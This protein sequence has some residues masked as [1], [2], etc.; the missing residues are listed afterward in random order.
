MHMFRPTSRTPLYRYIAITKEHW[1]M[2]PAVSTW[3]KTIK[4]KPDIISFNT[5]I[6]KVMDKIVTGNNLIFIDVLSM[7]FMVNRMRNTCCVIVTYSSGLSR[8]S[9]D[10]FDKNN[11][12]ECNTVIWLGSLPAKFNLSIRINLLYGILP[13]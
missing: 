13:A 2:A 12:H 8:R 6:H 3:K 1:Q 9:S 4:A 11:C 5:R 7:L 10:I